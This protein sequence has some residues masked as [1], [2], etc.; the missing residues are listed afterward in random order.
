MKRKVH[1]LT[2]EKTIEKEQSVEAEYVVTQNQPIITSH[3]LPNTMYAEMPRDQVD[4]REVH[5]VIIPYAPI[6]SATN[7]FYDWPPEP[8]FSNVAAS[9]PAASSRRILPSSKH[10]R[11]RSNSRDSISGFGS[12]HQPFRS[13]APSFDTME[14]SESKI[15][16]N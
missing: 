12:E 14:M 9:S 15:K 1:D 3:P 6:A 16:Q 10:N 13:R 4:L 2:A 7:R 8:E 11:L 5:H